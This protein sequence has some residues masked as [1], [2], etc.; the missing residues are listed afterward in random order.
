MLGSG[1]TKTWEC[2]DKRVLSLPNFNQKFACLKMAGLLSMC[3]SVVIYSVLY[4]ISCMYDLESSFSRRN[5]VFLTTL[6]EKLILFLSV[7]C[8]SS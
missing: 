5:D 6:Q 3:M 7:P 2:F 1:Y 8:I 4:G